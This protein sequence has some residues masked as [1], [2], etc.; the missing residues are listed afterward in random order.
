MAEIGHGYGSEWHLLRFLGRHREH[1]GAA[2]QRLIGCDTVSW[3]DFP[4]DPKNKKWKDVEWKG[5]DF[6]P[7]D[8]AARGKWTEFWPQTGRPPNWD[9]VGK[10]SVNGQR[11]WLL[12]EAKAHLGEIESSC[13]ASPAGGL[14]TIRAAFETT[15]KALDVQRDRDW[16][17][18]YYQF[19]NRVAVLY[20]LN[21]HDVPARLLFLYFTGD[22]FREGSADCPADEEGWQ[23]ALSKQAEHVGLPDG[24][25]LS[26]RIHKLF[27]PVCS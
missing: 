1:L 7:Q 4:F 26:S 8:G 13:Q 24:H 2:I 22:T 14:D 3:L 27:L 19:C 25:V 9:A 6:L 18:G 21:Q 12:V 15:K 17:S 10:V 16:L 11:E 20:F 5:L 23:E